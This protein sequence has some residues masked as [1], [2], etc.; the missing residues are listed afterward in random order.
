MTNIELEKLREKFEKVFYGPKSSHLTKFSKLISEEDYNLKDDVLFTLHTAVTKNSIDVV[1]FMLTNGADVARIDSNLVADLARDGKVSM[2]KLLFSE[3]L[4]G[5]NISS[6]AIVF[7]AVHLKVN[8]VKIL[9]KNGVDVSSKESSVIQSVKRQDR[10][11]NKEY[12]EI[13]K[14][15]VA[16]GA[17][18]MKLSYKEA[19]E[20]FGSPNDSVKSLTKN[21]PEKLI[22]A[23]VK[24]HAHYSKKGIIKLLNEAPRW[25]RPY[26]VKLMLN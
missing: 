23:Y 1:K 15:L 3:G 2:L 8:S 17:D 22:E 25:I 13:I 14:L 26:Y 7:A 11:S 16:S 20:I 21:S 6:S 19:S 12:R 18:I 24:R 10:T 4:D 5:K 9:L